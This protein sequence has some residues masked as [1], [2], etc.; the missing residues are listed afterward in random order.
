MKEA[1]WQTAYDRFVGGYGSEP[2]LDNQIDRHL[3]LELLTYEIRTRMEQGMA[4]FFN[5]ETQ[6][7]LEEAGK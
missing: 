3:F 4:D 6:K 7:L 2:D 5:A 1:E